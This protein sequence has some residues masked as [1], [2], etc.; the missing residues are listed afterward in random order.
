MGSGILNFS[1]EIIFEVDQKNQSGLLRPGPDTRTSQNKQ[2]RGPSGVHATHL[3]RL[4]LVACRRGFMKSLTTV[5]Q[6]LTF[7]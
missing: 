1:G 4:S 5:E 3:P 6:T 7:P 2:E